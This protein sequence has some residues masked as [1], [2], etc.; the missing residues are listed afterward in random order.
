MEKQSSSSSSSTATATATCLNNI[1]GGKGPTGLDTLGQ[2]KEEEGGKNE[3]E[4]GTYLT[5]L[6]FFF[7]TCSFT[8]AVSS[9]STASFSHTQMGKIWHQSITQCSCWSRI[10]VRSHDFFLKLHYF[11]H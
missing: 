10:G 1:S 8:T 4:E 7:P 2:R 11:A 3:K 5:L 9:S 6:S